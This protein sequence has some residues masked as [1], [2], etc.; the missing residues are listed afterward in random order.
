MDDATTAERLDTA[1]VTVIAAPRMVRALSARE[2]LSRLEGAEREELQRA[3]RSRDLDS[4][5]AIMQRYSDR[6]RIER[7]G[8]SVALQ[9]PQPMMRR[10]GGAGARRRSFKP[11]SNDVKP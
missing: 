2:L 1:P 7:E 4:V 6:A 8:Y 9:P 10:A 11:Y 3:M 5:R